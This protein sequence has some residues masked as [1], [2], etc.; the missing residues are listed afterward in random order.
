MQRFSHNSIFFLTL[1]LAI[2]AN[3]QSQQLSIN[4]FVVYSVKDLKLASDIK[5]LP[6]SN[7]ANGNVGSKESIS[8]KKSSVINA[9]IFGRGTIDLDKELA[10][11]GNI[12]ANNYTNKNGDILKGDKDISISGNIVVNGDLKLSSNG[13]SITGFVKQRPGASYTGPN[14]VLGRTNESLT[15]P[16]FPTLPIINDF[17]A[18]TLNIVGNQTIAPGEYNDVILTNNQTLRLNGVGTYVFKSITNSG[19]GKIN[20]VFNFQNAPTGHFRLFVTGKVNLKNVT[21]TTIN[22]GSASRIFT[23]IHSSLSTNNDNDDIQNA[24][25]LS[26]GSGNSGSNWLVT[27]WVPYGKIKIKS[28]G[29]APVTKV[30]G[31]I[32]GGDVIYIEKNIEIKYDPLIFD[33]NNISPYYPAPESGKINDLIGSELTQL[34]VNIGPITSI[35]DNNIFRIDTINN[36]PYVTI[37]AIAIDGQENALLAYLINQGLINIIS[38]GDNSLV[39]TGMFPIAN[40]QEL[41]EQ[42]TLLRYSRPLY[43][44]L[45][46]VGI[47]TSQGDTAMRSNLVRLGYDLAGTGVKVG[48]ISDSYNTIRNN[49]ALADV[50]NGDLPGPTNPNGNLTPVQIV[51]EF[52]FGTRIDEGRAMLQIIHDVAPKSTLAFRTGFISAGD[53]AEGIRELATEGCQIIVD[54]VTYITEPFFRDGVVAQAVDEVNAAGVTYVSAAGNYGTK[55]YEAQFSPAIA[56]PGTF[57]EAHNFGSSVYQRLVLVPGTYTIVLQWDD[58]VYSLKNNT[59]TQT[60]LDIWLSNLDGTPLFGFN[61]NNLG[62]DPIEV[63]PFN[64]NETTTTNIIVSKAAGPNVRFKYIIFR[65]EG[66]IDDPSAGAGTIVGQANAAG[67]I[68][69]GAVLFLNTPAYGG[70]ASSASFSSRGGVLVNNANRNKP[71]ISGPNGVNTTVDLKGVNID[72]DAFPNFFGTSAAAPHIAA[73]AALLIEA[74]QKFSNTSIS[75]DSIRLIMKNTAG[76]ISGGSSVSGAGFI[77][78]DEMIKTFAKPKPKL[79]SI[80]SVGNSDF[81]PGSTLLV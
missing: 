45:T 55:S 63:L 53:F 77:R 35:P 38:N 37:E 36:I 60:D 9:N 28:T 56:P 20:I 42:V 81:E 2:N 7:M 43:E 71:D 68:S 4:D 79:R 47:T 54:D 15:L 33:P 30:E 14:P 17:E 75:N 52:P 76:P 39:I 72:G 18:G 44:P 50:S 62:G 59:G 74:K 65:G 6:S 12:T 40:L 46:K 16:I 13:S 27:L 1:L 80:F 10:I 51:Q 25:F 48:V 73:A 32:W 29:N 5:V 49:P 69:V 57:G 66:I 3:P 34:S 78:A 64:V 58:D 41:N 61:R 70:V 31:A 26:N 22:G 67:A 24:F 11:S 8:F 23:E 21:V 19:N